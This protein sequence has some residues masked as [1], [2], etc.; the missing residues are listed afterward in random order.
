MKRKYMSS[1][2]FEAM[3]E[4]DKIEADVVYVVSDKDG[5]KFYAVSP[6]GIG[7]VFFDNN[8]DVKAAF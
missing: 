7:F 8:K 3:Q 1:V 2:A 6:D 4:Q 5:N